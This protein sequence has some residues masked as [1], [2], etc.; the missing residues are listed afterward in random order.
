M[1]VVE[2][3]LGVDWMEGVLLFD[4]WLWVCVAWRCL[5]PG[6]GRLCG[7]SAAELKE[8]CGLLTAKQG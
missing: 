3:G 2:R 7:S 5:Q 6:G 1:L 8:D 4:E